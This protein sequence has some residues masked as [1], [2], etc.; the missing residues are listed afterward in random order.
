[1]GGNWVF[2]FF[3][4]RTR[5]TDPGRAGRKK[6]FIPESLYRRMINHCLEEVPL[7]AC[8]LLGG[9]AGHV[10]SGYAT[11][12]ARR[13]PVVYQVDERQLLQAW[14]QILD[15][16]QEIIGIYHSHVKSDPVPS[17]TDIDQATFP[18]AFYLIVSLKARRPLVRAWR[19]VDRQVSE[20]QV[21]IT[22]ETGGVWQDLR[23]AVQAAAEPVPRSDIP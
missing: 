2:S 20:H 15:Q 13:S 11:D 1:M 14:R 5:K 23:R 22:K 7:E 9:V 6:L 12:N 17:L 3:G 18:E 19:I 21:V 8:G 10:L 16:K 4:K